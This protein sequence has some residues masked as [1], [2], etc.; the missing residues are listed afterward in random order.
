MP[1]I[2]ESHFTP[3]GVSG[4]TH[5]SYYKHSPPDGGCSNG[6]GQRSHFLAVNM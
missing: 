1:L 4:H 2:T 5:I 6:S 3:D